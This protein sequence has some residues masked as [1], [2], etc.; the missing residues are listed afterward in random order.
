LQIEETR[1]FFEHPE[2]HALSRHN[3]GQYVEY[4]KQEINRIGTLNQLLAKLYEAEYG[5]AKE[6]TD[7]V[8]RDEEFSRNLARTQQLYDGIITQLQETNLSKDFG[9]F[10]ADVIAPPG[11]GVKVEPKA[12]TV[13]LTSTV[14]GVLLGFGLAFVADM[15]D[16]TFRRPEEMSAALEV[17]IVGLIP[18]YIPPALASE[19]AAGRLDHS[20][21]TYHWPMS[22][23]SEAYR[24]LRTG[25]YFKNRGKANRVIQVTSP[26]PGDGKTTIAA[27]LSICIA[28]SGKQVL[29]IDA[30]MRKPRQHRIF[31]I[32]ST[33]GV[34][35]LI[36]MDEELS[37]VVRP[38]SIDN[39]WLL[40]AGQLPP[41]P[42]ELLTSARFGELIQ[43]VRERYDYVIM[44][45]GPLLAISDPSII[46]S[47]VDSVVLTMRL[48]KTQ[49]RQ[50]ERA[51]ELL[52]SLDAPVTGV[53]VNAVGEMEAS[54]Y[55][56]GDYGDYHHPDAVD[57][58]AKPRALM[59][60]ASDSV[61]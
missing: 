4:L 8:L 20:L 33:S 28:Q 45:T 17:P 38:T 47:H 54:V 15:S 16:N 42:A 2:R 14:L 9:G 39:L 58:S 31:G 30:D 1:A 22:A 46:L 60:D 37:D 40:P 59:V 32:G 26:C 35:T 56:Y 51:R 27:N 61:A 52:Q 49:R 36:A 7:Y 25:L 13:F 3:T 11:F 5:E 24:G 57:L 43:L 48:K 55:G 50:A 44:D 41:D 34:S 29:L 6:L 12:S 10:K 18:L 53:V 21:S 19:I 23:Q